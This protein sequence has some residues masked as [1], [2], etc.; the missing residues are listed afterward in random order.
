MSSKKVF[1]VNDKV[2]AKIRGYPAWPAIVSSVKTDT[3]TRLRYSV[4][5]YGTGER[6]EC[7]P[8][9]LCPYEENKSRLGKPNKRKYFAEALLQIEDSS[10]TLVLPEEE[11]EVF[12]TPSNTSSVEQ[13]D[14]AIDDTEVEKANESNSESEKKLTVDESNVLK[15]KKVPKRSLGISRGT[16]RK[17]SDVKPEA[18]SKKSLPT[19]AKCLETSDDKE[20]NS[21]IVLVENIHD[22]IF[23]KVHDI[24]VS[25]L[26][27]MFNIE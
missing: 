26:K 18:S 16:K 12:T 15:G 5:F 27:F 9:D 24:Q 19:K 25:M 7:K 2:F 17:I 20:S 8:E 11:P 21:P 1:N 10:G 4:Y 23:E 3:P 13:V 6:A 14:Y 22:K